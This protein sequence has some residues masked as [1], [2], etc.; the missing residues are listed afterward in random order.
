MLGTVG[1][2]SKKR[3]VAY[4]ASASALYIPVSAAMLSCPPVAVCKLLTWIHTSPRDSAASDR[5]GIQKCRDISAFAQTARASIPYVLW[6]FF[7]EAGVTIRCVKCSWE[8]NPISP[9]RA[10]ELCS[11]SV[12]GYLIF[13]HGRTQET[14]VPA[15]LCS[16][17]NTAWKKQTSY[18]MSLL[19]AWLGESE[20][21]GQILKICWVYLPSFCEHF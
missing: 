6:C 13:F 4:W 16:E 20:S 17:W 8:S 1:A 3:T 10:R 21:A 15:L 11:N 14:T 5:S 9:V 2:L 7:S 12:P 18:C 19:R